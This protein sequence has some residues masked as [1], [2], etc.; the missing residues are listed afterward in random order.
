MPWLRGLPEIGLS[1][2]VYLPPLPNDDETDVVDS[3]IDNHD[4]N[5]DLRGTATGTE[6]RSSRS[7]SSNG[8]EGRFA[9]GIS[10]EGTITTTNNGR[11]EEQEGAAGEDEAGRGAGALT[12]LLL[13]KI[14]SDRRFVRTPQGTILNLQP[15]ATVKW[16]SMI[17]PCCLIHFN[18][19][20]CFPNM[21]ENVPIT[22]IG[23]GRG[24]RVAVTRRVQPV[25]RCKKR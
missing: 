18:I 13:S 14:A 8:I 23:A 17:W 5:T 16:I 3:N 6:T 19:K 20:T 4:T 12:Q 9:I 21:Y 1:P 11:G 2:L 15:D 24:C 7:S 22:H 25:A 10:K